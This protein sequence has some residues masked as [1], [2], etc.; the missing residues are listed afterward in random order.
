MSE[1]EGS[2][3]D[4]KAETK[5]L[6]RNLE[7]ARSTRTRPASMRKTR[8]KILFV[9]ENARETE[10]TDEVLRTQRARENDGTL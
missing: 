8:W 3:T 6:G 2:E 9:W 1:K 10:E 7:E 4:T 5:T